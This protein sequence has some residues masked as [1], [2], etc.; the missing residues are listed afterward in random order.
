MNLGE[1]RI[2]SISVSMSSL[3]ETFISRNYWA[4]I[5]ENQAHSVSSYEWLGSTQIE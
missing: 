4:H 1:D 5:V 2:Q 3:K